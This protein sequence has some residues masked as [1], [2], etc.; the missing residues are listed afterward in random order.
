MSTAWVDAALRRGPVYFDEGQGCWTVT[1]HPEAL[2]VLGDPVTFSS[3]LADLVPRQEDLDLFRRGNIVQ[4][5][6]PRHDE[7]RRIV[8]RA[9]TPR[10]VAGLEPRIE[11]ITG[12]LLDARGSRFDLIDDLAY[13]LP[14]IVIAELLGV[15]AADRPVFRRWADRLFDRAGERLLDEEAIAAV[16][17]AVHEMREYLLEH[18][19]R[20]R[21]EP[22]DDLTTALVREGLDDE[23]AA[24]F[25][26][27][28]LIAGH[29]TTTATLGNTVLCLHETPGAAD[30]LRAAPD[31]LPGAIEEA[32]RLRTPFPRLARRT[33]TATVL[34][35]ASLPAD[36]LVAIWLAAANRDPRVFA[37]PSAYDPR[38]NPNPHLAFGHGIHFCLGAP[39]AR[40]EARVALRMLLRRYR[41]IAVDTAEP[42]RFRNPWV[43]SSPTRLPIAVS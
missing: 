1:G 6:P 9:F 26:G 13:P 32:L 22:A 19:R 11:A 29:I 4:M 31:L 2:A 10:V 37:D 16:A 14:V 41:E 23:A 38:R 36:T 17:P 28:L 18:V 30:E 24:G 35:D 27:V 34:G 5:D 40:L 33:T 20:R 15:P 25:V 21:A 7:L 3:D 12:S 42:I 8:S 39:L 43:M